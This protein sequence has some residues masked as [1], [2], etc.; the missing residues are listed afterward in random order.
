MT[1]HRRQTAVARL[2]KQELYSLEKSITK[3]ET[4][5]KP[6]EQTEVNPSKTKVER[7]YSAAYGVYFPFAKKVMLSLNMKWL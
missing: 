5:T 1:N 6:I 4:Q 3:S 2:K 7:R